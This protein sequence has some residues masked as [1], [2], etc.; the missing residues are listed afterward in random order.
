M[1]FETDDDNVSDNDNDDDDDDEDD[2]EAMEDDAV[3]QR[4]HVRRRH[5]DRFDLLR[6]TMKTNSVGEQRVDIDLVRQVS[7]SSRSVVERQYVEEVRHQLCA[8]QDRQLDAND[9]RRWHDEYVRQV[10]APCLRQR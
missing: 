2:D 10:R 8:E 4:K 7:L 9:L 1:K 5:T 6:T 3:R